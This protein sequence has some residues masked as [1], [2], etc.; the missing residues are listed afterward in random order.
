MT[1]LLSGG[2]DDDKYVQLAE[3]NLWLRKKE[4][5]ILRLFS[6]KQRNI[7]APFA[8]GRQQIPPSSSECLS[9]VVSSAEIKRDH[10][11]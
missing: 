7:S 9:R 1:K 8:T 6:C 4:G 11:L 3:Q 10:A 2:P 5:K